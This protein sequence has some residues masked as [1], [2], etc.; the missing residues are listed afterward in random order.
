MT[1][2]DAVEILMKE[3]RSEKGSN[4]ACQRCVRALR[5]LDFGNDEIIKTLSWLDYCHGD[6]GDPYNNVKI[7]RTW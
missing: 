5:Y 7:K 2:V 6:S 3:A 4:A 1:K